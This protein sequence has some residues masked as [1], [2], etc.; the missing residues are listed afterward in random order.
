M[1]NTEGALKR[2]NPFGGYD[3]RMRQAGLHYH[4]PNDSCFISS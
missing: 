3:N 4:H 1:G 2:R